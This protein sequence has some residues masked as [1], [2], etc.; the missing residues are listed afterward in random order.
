MGHHVYLS[1][2][3]HV[4]WVTHIYCEVLLDI[5][6]LVTKDGEMMGENQLIAYVWHYL[7]T[8]SNT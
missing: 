1:C 2:Y 4:T 6:S 5:N 8:I 3:E 7:G